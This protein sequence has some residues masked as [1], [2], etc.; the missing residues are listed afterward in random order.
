MPL[1]PD[2]SFRAVRKG[3]HYE[4]N[5]SYADELSRLRGLAEIIYRRLEDGK[6][7]SIQD[8]LYLNDLLTEAM[9]AL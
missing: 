4:Y 1:Q 8:V 3:W 5:E 7:P 9:R 2:G 6:Q